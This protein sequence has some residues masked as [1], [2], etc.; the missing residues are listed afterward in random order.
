MKM[1]VHVSKIIYVLKICRC[2]IDAN[3]S[4]DGIGKITSKICREPIGIDDLFI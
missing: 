1:K 4:T 2:S 3:V